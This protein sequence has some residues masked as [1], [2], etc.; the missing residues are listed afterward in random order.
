MRQGLV[1]IVV[2]AAACGG[3][4]GIARP[5]PAP[6]AAP[7]AAT[8]AP[9][10]TVPPV[11][12]DRVRNVE[13]TLVRLVVR[14]QELPLVEGSVAT[15]LIDDADRVAGRASVNRYAGTLAPLMPVGEIRWM[16]P[17]FA[18][19][20]MAGPPELMRQEDAF[21]L[22]L[23]Q[24]THVEVVGERLVLRSEDGAMRLEF[25]R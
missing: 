14:G 10:D 20:K 13:W 1:G 8:A 23:G 16:S 21:L 22:A 2:A 4:D 25:R 24:T 3:T 12:R 19:T 11:P 9:P 7:M 15:F 17:G 18:V 6:A 5:A